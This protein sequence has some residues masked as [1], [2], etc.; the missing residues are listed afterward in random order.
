M[1]LPADGG[2]PPKHVAVKIVYFYILYFVIAYV[3][4]S[5]RKS[6]KGNGK[7]EVCYLGMNTVQYYNCP[8]VHFHLLMTLLGRNM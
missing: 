4:L 6:D 1:L 2:R 5:N 3:G 8:F 7:I